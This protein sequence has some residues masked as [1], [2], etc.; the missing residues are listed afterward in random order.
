MINE[1]TRCS[2]AARNSHQCSVEI[3]IFRLRRDVS[4]AKE[5]PFLA[6]FTRP[7]CVVCVTTILNGEGSQRGISL[8]GDDDVRWLRSKLVSQPCFSLSFY[9][10]N[11]PLLSV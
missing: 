6:L 11:R 5:D 2:T 4:T 8:G 9:N 10:Q 1:T 3:Q 7:K